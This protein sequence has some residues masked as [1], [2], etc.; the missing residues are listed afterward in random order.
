[1]KHIVINGDFLMHRITGVQRYALEVTKGIDEV[2]D[3]VCDVYVELLL[4]SDCTAALQLKN[5]K[6][7]RYGKY[8]RLFWLQYDLMKYCR[9]KKA[10]CLCMATVV[11]FFYTRHSANVIHD[12]CTLTHPEFYSKQYLLMNRVLL[13]GIIHRLGKIFTV[14]HFSK[15]EIVRYTHVRPERITVA[16]NSYEHLRNINCDFSILKELGLEKKTYFYSLSS[17]SPNKNFKW[18]LEE[19]R[20]NPA[21]TFVISGM[22]IELFSDANLYDRPRNVIF[23]GYLSDEQVKALLTECK[24]FLFPTWYEG[25]GIPP[26]EALSCGAKITVSD[27]PVMHEIYENCANYIDPHKTT[28]EGN[29]LLGKNEHYEKILAKYSWKETATVILNALR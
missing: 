2:L 6:I 23:T 1:M 5:I 25:F 14:S 21:E 16:Y 13:W 8:R 9:K 3:N 4:P 10:I 12:A 24:T 26:L 15:N 11:P 22:K 20:Q 17:L 19:A 29:E 18:I 27:I 28:Y 7:I